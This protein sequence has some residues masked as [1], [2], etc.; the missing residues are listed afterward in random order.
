MECLIDSPFPF[1]LEEC[2]LNEEGITSKGLKIIAQ[3]QSESICDNSNEL[4]KFFNIIDSECKD[5]RLW[6]LF[7]SDNNKRWLP[8]Q[9]A[10]VSAEKKDIRYEIKSDFKRMIPF[11]PKTDVRKWTSKF[12]GYIM[13]VEI[14]RD[15]YCQK[16]AKLREKTKI[17]AVAIL[18]NEQYADI[19]NSIITK[20]QK[21]EIDLANELKPLIWN[22]SPQEMKYLTNNDGYIE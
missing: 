6:V 7:G 8:L 18:I 2:L 5:K 4:K 3:I 20:Y 14:G 22:P 13:N 10:S 1:G 16:Y 17:L 19:D 15:I 12:H 21:K 11:N 9:L